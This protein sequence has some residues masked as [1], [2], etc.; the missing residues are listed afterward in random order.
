MTRQEAGEGAAAEARMAALQ[1]VA[2]GVR[3]RLRVKPGASREAVLGLSVL[4]SGEG[5]VTVSLHAVAEGGKANAALAGLLAKTWRLPKSAVTLASGA[6]ARTKLVHVAAEGE[7]LAR[8][9][10]WYAGLPP[11][12]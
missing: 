5:V 7:G 11:L 8:I 2:D 3:L 12:K 9:L 4:A 10:D 6:A 1:R